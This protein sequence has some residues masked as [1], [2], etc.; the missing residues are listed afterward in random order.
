[1]RY[2]SRLTLVLVG[3]ALFVL[4]AVLR[5]GDHT[6]QAR[7]LI[8][9]LAR[10]EWP[11]VVDMFDTT[12]R[13]ALPQAKLPELWSSLEA[14]AG[15]F[16]QQEGT[17]RESAGGYELVFV[18][19]RFERA[20]LELKVVFDTAGKVAGFFVA[21]SAPAQPWQPPAYCRVDA[22]DNREVTVG[23]GEWSLPGTLS[24]PAG[25]G[26]HPAV[27]LVHGSGP[28]DR[29]ETIGPNKPFADLA[30]GLAS[31][32]V[33]VL[34]YEKRTKRHAA[35]LAAATAP[36]TVKEET[37]EDAVAAAALVRG[38]AGIDPRRVFVLGHSLGGMLLPRIARA[39]TSL[40]GL[41]ALAG[42]TRPIEEMM[43]E[44]L[45]YIS[46]LPGTPEAARH[47]IAQIEAGVAQVKALPASKATSAERVLGVPASYWL[48]LRGYRPA[49]EA[50][51]LKQ[52]M[53]VLQGGRDYQ[54]TLED[55]DNW[56]RAL[57]ER[58]NVEL[59]VYP[60]LNH[61]FVAGEGKSTPAEYEKPG[62]V[63]ESVVTD[64]ATWIGR[65]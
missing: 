58:S 60:E 14:Q 15:R 33:A 11:A 55:F 2:V 63:A 3:A 28:Q 57:G 29:D 18:T 23:A 10:A 21:S 35:K 38:S 52:P 4:P 17:R 34:R 61:L 27:V 44:Q 7:E 6:P 41:V 40:R 53:L 8:A 20:V 26:P 54:V 31:R 43:L 46:S 48:D 24:V 13:A 64:I 19:C 50:R 49:E 39:D 16:Q 45:A 42:A 59:R 62:H 25:A 65:R 47:Q 12:M 36:L 22:I 1:M 37:V 32:G 51:T 30:C 56:K 9:R 5:A